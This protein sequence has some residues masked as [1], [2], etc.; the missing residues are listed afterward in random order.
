MTTVGRTPAVRLRQGGRRVASA[1]LVV[2]AMATGL[3]WHA[4]RLPA[5]YGIATMGT[6]DWGSGPVVGHDHGVATSITTLIEPGSRRPDVT[7]DLVARTA[8]VRLDARGAVKGFSINGQTPG[9]TLRA[10]QGQLV[11]VRLVN[12]GITDGVTLH[13]HGVAVPN[14]MDGVAGVTQDAV[15]PGES[16][17]YRFVVE[18]PGTYWY[19]SH[20]QSHPQTTGGLFGALVVEPVRGGS[21]VTDA[22]ALIHTFAGTRSING[23]EG[24]RSVPASPG[25]VVRVRVVN[26]D[27][28]PMPVWVSGSSFRLLAVDGR[29]LNGATDVLDRGVLVTAG[30]RADLSVRVPA[31]GGV[32]VQVAGASLVLGDV[33]GSEVP[34]SP[35]PRD[36][37]D[38]LTYGAPLPLP[39]DPGRPTRTF[40][41][42]IGARLGLL[43]GR[44][45]RYWTVNG[46]LYPDVPMFMVRRGDVVRFHV[47]NDSGEVHPMHLHGHHVLV[48]SR[49]GVPATGTPWWVDSLN[50]EQGESYEVAFMA[51][52]P[53]IWMDHCH[54]LPHAQQGLVAHLMYAG[55]TTPFVLGGDH[56]NVPE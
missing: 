28:G 45:G 22:V 23:A 18:H 56:A 42:A 20:Q 35:A 43:D 25:E 36:L 5:S 55:Y 17:V 12:E 50:V 27:P 32:R 54:N 7:Y 44:P 38:L 31:S 30:G 37:L 4:S 10:V 41:Y 19:H 34:V 48:L 24:D 21:S 47:S 40:E 8:D 39:F 13:W 52:N 49:N 53:G 15:R 29:E 33:P 26:T 1:A 3:L 46:H 14:A 2:V 16:F 9:P 6:P 11:Q 51:D